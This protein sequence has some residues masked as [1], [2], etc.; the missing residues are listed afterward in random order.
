[1]KTWEATKMASLR[2]AKAGILAA[3]GQGGNQGEPD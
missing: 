3:F 1:M 2:F